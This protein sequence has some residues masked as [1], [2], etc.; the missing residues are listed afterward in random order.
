MGDDKWPW[1]V[2]LGGILAPLNDV[3]PLWLLALVILYVVFAVTMFFRWL[4]LMFRGFWKGLE[5]LSRGDLW[6]AAKWWGVTVVPVVIFVLA[7]TAMSLLERWGM[8][9]LDSSLRFVGIPILLLMTLIIVG[10]GIVVCFWGFVAEAL[11]LE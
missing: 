2:D 10:E 3:W 5:S 9:G 11:D 8:L 6:T 7:N 4:L 1:Y